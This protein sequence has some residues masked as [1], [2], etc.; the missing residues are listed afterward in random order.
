VVV[1][2]EFPDNLANPASTRSFYQNLLFSTTGT[3]M[4][5][6]F[7]ENSWDQL[8]LSGTV[9]WNQTDNGWVM[10][11]KAYAYYVN[12]QE[13][14]GYYPQNTQKL[15]EDVLQIIDPYTNFAQHDGDGDGVLDGLVIVYA[16]NSGG[17]DK[18]W[19]HMWSI[20]TQYRDGIAISDY[21]VVP[22]FNEQ[23][24]DIEIS[25]YCHEYSHV[26]GAYDLYDYDYSSAGVGLWSLMGW[27]HSQHLDPW[28]KALLGWI[29]PSVL[30]NNE[31]RLS[32]PQVET[33]KLIYRLNLGNPSEYYLVENRAR[34]GYDQNLPGE[35]LLIWHIDEDAATSYRINDNEWYPPG[36]MGSGHF[37]VAVEQ[38]DGLYELEQGTNVGDASDPFRT[39]SSFTPITNP[40]SCDYMGLNHNIQ[41]TNITSMSVILAD[42]NFDLIYPA[43]T[44]W[45]TRLENLTFLLQGCT[46]PNGQSTTAWF[47]WGLSKAYGNNTPP[48]HFEG[49]AP[50]TVTA[51]LIGPFELQSTYHYRIV[52]Q[53]A[54]GT[55]FGED[56]TFSNFSWYSLSIA[57][58]A[59][60]GHASVFDIARQKMIVF[61]GYNGSLLND[62]WSY[63][64]AINSWTELNPSNP[65]SP[66]FDH[67]M[68]YDSSRDRIIMFGGYNNG[69][70]NDTWSYDPATNSWTELNP[71]N[72]PPCRYR[73]ALVYNPTDG[74]IILFGGASYGTCLDDTWAYDPDT[75]RWTDL[76]P[77]NSPPGRQLH[78][79]VYNIAQG[80]V[81]LFGGSLLGGCVPTNPLDDT[82]SFNPLNNSW[83]NLNPPCHPEARFN[84]AMV[85]DQIS[86]QIILF[87]GSKDLDNYLDDTWSYNIL[88]NV[89]TERYP[90]QRPY[91][92]GGHSLVIDPIFGFVILFGGEDTKGCL[93]DIWFYDVPNGDWNNLGLANSLAPRSEHSMVYDSARGQII[94]FGGRGRD[95]LLN[96]TWSF[97]VKLKKWTELNPSNP[98]SPRFGH[99]MVYDSSRDRI[100]MFGGANN[101]RCLDDTWSYDPITNSW[102][103][104]NPSNPPPRPLVFGMVYD[105]NH[106]QVVLFTEDKI[107]SYHPATNSWTSLNPSSS[108]PARIHPGIALDSARSLVILFG[109]SELYGNHC[110][111]D[112]WAYD[113]ESNTWTNLNPISKPGA[114][115]AHSMIYDP[116]SDRVVLFGGIG[117]TFINDTLAY[118]PLND[119]WAY[120]LESNTW[121]NL[122]PLSK[123][124]QRW[125]HAMTY[126]SFQSQ[127]ILFGGWGYGGFLN[128]TW[129]FPSFNLPTLTITSPNGGESWTIGSTQ[130]ITWISSNLIGN[131]KIELNRNYPSGTWEILFVNT[132][133]D[134]SESWQVSGPSSSSCRLR[135]TS[136]S[137]PSVSDLSDGNFSIL[138]PPSF[139]FSPT[140]FTFLATQGGA[141][142]PPQTLEVWN[143]GGG[144]MNWT[145]SKNAN[146]LTLS[147]TSGNSS[148]EHDKIAISVNISGLSSGTYSATITLTGEEVSNSPQYITVTLNVL[149]PPSNFFN[150]NL[151]QGWNAISLPLVTDPRPATVFQGV[152]GDWA[153]FW[154]DPTLPGP[155]GMGGYVM[156]PNLA[157]GK[158]YWMKIFG[159][160][161]VVTISGS[162]CQESP[163]NIPLYSGWNMIGNPFLKEM[164]V[165]LILVETQGGLMT[166]EEAMNTGVISPFFLY[167][168]TGYEL[169]F[170]SGQF[171]PGKGYWVK[172]FQNC[173]LVVFNPPPD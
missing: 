31:T 134:G 86:G 151:S 23:P 42:F 50:K 89:W 96:D 60:F 11:P 68:V 128:D 56:K 165:G 20:N 5:T 45:P 18:I 173:T 120:D 43:V 124:C 26:L 19:P 127:I 59:R 118:N 3:S 156:N 121:T 105:P 64:P 146:W 58:F 77:S 73:H 15:V 162:P 78:S 171:V 39:G 126:D 72:P 83:T 119:T 80:Q 167:N 133:N 154:W 71:S 97:D 106:D 61:G 9:Y 55:F 108:P 166:I 169:I 113:L 98:P 140:S 28:H 88:N 76:K 33:S 17:W 102:T 164:S 74:G 79:M 29:E 27:D 52:C 70:L 123:P 153:L 62:T 99:A 139:S 136:L 149:P 101:D 92:R 16:G 10:A 38:A 95:G 34:I 32:I 21:C 145:A 54:S 85:Y 48:I 2:V 109:G 81:I 66:R 12:N 7:K 130:N 141:N 30:N 6:F 87:G 46:N 172:A 1:L 152:K 65:P 75:N 51:T 90:S 137:N 161:Q 104:L 135:L 107:W 157:P 150:L 103:E 132:P 93:D 44:W 116:A 112:T 4:T 22:E 138:S 25:V 110:L 36:H 122:R 49:N 117:I 13:G 14:L 67:A 53:N 147:P 125:L 35:G 131:V 148:G 168:G 63:D 129:V 160:S 143:S 40:S 57:P 163:F 69:P 82:W 158:G 24:L 144:S 142:P 84:H 170:A 115:C 8:N 114:R 47:E 37:T 100:I 155:N 159:G 91:S 94:L 111:N 41:I